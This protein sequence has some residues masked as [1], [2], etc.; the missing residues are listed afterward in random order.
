MDDSDMDDSPENS[1]GLNYHIFHM[2]MIFL[3]FVI[4]IF[5]R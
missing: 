4:K 5:G 1:E 3:T 2:L